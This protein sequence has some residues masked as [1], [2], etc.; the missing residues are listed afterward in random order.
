MACQFQ[1]F[2]SISRAQYEALIDKAVAAGFNISGDSGQTLYKGMNISWAYY[3]DTLKLDIECVDKPWYIRCET[4]NKK[5]QSLV[6]DTI[7]GKG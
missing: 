2:E 5:I 4:V 3:P 1:H 6:T 7:K